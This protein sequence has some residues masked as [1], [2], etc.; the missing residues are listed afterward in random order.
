[1][2]L[3]TEMRTELDQKV[4]FRQR[5]GAKWLAGAGSGP[6]HEILPSFHCPDTRDSLCVQIRSVSWLAMEMTIP[7]QT[8]VSIPIGGGLP[9]TEMEKVLTSGKPKAIRVSGFKGSFGDKTIIEDVD[10]DFTEGTITAIVGP[11]GCGKSTFLRSLNR[12]NDRIPGWSCQGSVKFYGQDV[13]SGQLDLLSLRRR[14]GMVFQ[15][16]NPFPMS[17]EENVAAGVKAHR[18]APRSQI[19]RIV[20]DR[21]EEVGLFNAV[22]DRLKDSPFRLSGGQQQLLCLARALAVQPDVL[23][24]DEPT[25]SLDPISTEAVEE[26]L[27]EFVPDLSIVVVTHNLAQARRIADRV[28]FFMDGRLVEVGDTEQ[29]FEDPQEVETGRYV[30]GRIG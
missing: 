19:H 29:I 9:L 12:M 8:E 14:I 2:P 26:L 3:F 23:L 27:K 6:G 24:L 4:A 17:I 10:L 15:R 11:S 16:P 22:K 30:S 7:L 5:V 1:M 13:Y 18:L 25:S 28:A 20:Q 21:L